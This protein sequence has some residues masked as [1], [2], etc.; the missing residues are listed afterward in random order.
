MLERFTENSRTAEEIGLGFN[1][2]LDAN[3][4]FTQ[5]IITAE[6]QE[7]LR[8]YVEIPQHIIEL[9][10]PYAYLKNFRL[11]SWIQPD[12]SLKWKYAC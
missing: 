6:Q 7:L 3:A 10:I 5:S 8:E 2:N 1:L 9:W 4:L 12:A 11:R